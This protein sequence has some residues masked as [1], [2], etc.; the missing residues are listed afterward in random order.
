MIDLITPDEAANYAL[1]L[2]VVVE[3]LERHVGGERGDHIVA[4]SN[5]V[6]AHIIAESRPNTWN[7]TG[8]GEDG[9]KQWHAAADSEP[10]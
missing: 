6:A 10:R 2:A 5:I 3:S 4:A 1:S 9:H 7:W 8:F